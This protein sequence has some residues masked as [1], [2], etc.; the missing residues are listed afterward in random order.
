MV[1]SLGEILNNIV[2]P[3]R[4]LSDI[5]KD[6]REAERSLQDATSE[7]S[8]SFWQSLCV[9]LEDE[10]HSFGESGRSAD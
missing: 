8:K 6:Y 7:N 4:T 10:L 1:S 2:H 3:P 5:A 9:N